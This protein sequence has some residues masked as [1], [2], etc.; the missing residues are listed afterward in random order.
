MHIQG[1]QYLFGCEKLTIKQKPTNDSLVVRAGASEVKIEDH[2]LKQD[3]YYQR[4]L[5]VHMIKSGESLEW[6][7]D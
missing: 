4:M 6:V 7:V 3:R 2:I 1:D 5:V